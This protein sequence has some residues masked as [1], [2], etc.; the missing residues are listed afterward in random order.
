MLCTAFLKD[1]ATAKNVTLWRW[2]KA[3]TRGSIVT[4]SSHYW[5]NIQPGRWNIWNV[6]KTLNMKNKLTHKIFSNMFDFYPQLML[7]AG[8]IQAAGP[9]TYHFLPLALRSL[10]KLI[11]LIDQTMRE[12]GAQKIAMP[13]LTKADLWK[14]SG[15]IFRGKVPHISRTNR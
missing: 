11:R 6:S 12:I 4:R 9:G 7:K 10:E 14:T 2:D 15:K 13:C 1:S 3:A 5:R 8:L